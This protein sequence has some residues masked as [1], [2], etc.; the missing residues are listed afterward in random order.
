MI[1]ISMLPHGHSYPKTMLTYWF[2]V[3]VN[4]MA[5]HG[6]DTVHLPCT[7]PGYIINI[8]PIFLGIIRMFSMIYNIWTTCATLCLALRM[9]DRLHFEPSFLHQTY[10]IPE[11]APIQ[12]CSVPGNGW[13]WSPTASYWDNKHC[14]LFHP[15]QTHT[16]THS[17]SL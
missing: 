9:L 6:I 8:F 4:I 10:E 12:S 7:L 14:D 17:L 5:W 13:L 11:T 15:S 2:T 16:N 1:F 3:C